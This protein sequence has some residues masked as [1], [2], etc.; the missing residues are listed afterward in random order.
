M[1][2]KKPKT[3][4]NVPDEFVSE[5]VEVE[6]ILDSR[7]GCM[8]WIRNEPGFSIW[9]SDA[10]ISC[11]CWVHDGLTRIKLNLPRGRE[12]QLRDGQGL[13]PC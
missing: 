2:E 3:F 4:V 8:K 9:L 5:I 10:P 12:L 7:I 11:C 1:P 6:A 13:T